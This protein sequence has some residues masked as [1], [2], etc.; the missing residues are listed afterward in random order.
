MKPLGSVAAVVAAILEEAD[1][2]ADAIDR[3]A[4]ASIAALPSLAHD[5]PLPEDV[6]TIAAA[7]ERARIAVA[8]ED[9]ED[10]RA[11][12]SAR[13]AWFA[14]AV[15]AGRCRL[16]SL[17]TATARRSHLAAL[18]RE[19]LDRL[20]AGPIEIAV[21]AADASLLDDDWKRGVF[22]PE[23]A[24]R[25]SIATEVIDGGLVARTADG[26]VQFDNTW[27]ARAERLQA[28][29]RSALADLYEHGWPP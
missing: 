5:G 12:L 22:A 17:E 23:D 28:T 24:A 16:G 14:R 1:A 18:A 15:E 3:D 2:E 6:S 7:R 10:A 4:A 8:Q 26:R 21:S 27:S 19:A 25:V 20:P 9:W 13:E 11:A 29:W